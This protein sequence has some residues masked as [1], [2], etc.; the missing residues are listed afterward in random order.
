MGLCLSCDPVFHGQNG[1]W[2]VDVLKSLV[3]FFLFSLCTGGLPQGQSYAQAGQED[4]VYRF[5]HWVVD[6]VRALI[7]M[8]Q[9]RRAGFVAGGAAAGLLALS[10]ADERVLN[11]A[12]GWKEGAPH[13]V[14][15]F[16]NEIG[17]VRGV[18]PAAVM[19]FI[20]SLTSDD[21][22]FQDAAFTSLEAIVFANLTTDVLKSIVGRARPYDGKGPHHFRPFGGDLSFPSGHATTVLAFTTPWMMY[23]PHW[24]TYTLV[25]FS[26]GTAI[27]RLA[28]NV[29]WYTDVVAGGTIGFLMAQWLSRRHMEPAE[30]L[31]EIEP[32]VSAGTVG[33][34][35][36]L[37]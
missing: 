13:N 27:A 6:D 30:S 37:R 34:R 33:V 24:A 19:L 8:H 17:N 3:C 36:K 22:R 16:F 25:A 2:L 5:A 10:F 26:A 12:R 32:Y 11:Q 20:G 1:C 28:D 7:P 31:V 23:Y 21:T 18:R 4:D 29:H 35:V 9:S 14:F 15:R